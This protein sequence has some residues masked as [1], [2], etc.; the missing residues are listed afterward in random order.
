MKSRKKLWNI[1]PVRLHG[2]K[3]LVELQDFA[4]RQTVMETL[5]Q[6]DFKLISEQRPLSEQR[7]TPF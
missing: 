2:A 3:L 6:F 1:Q 4:R 5:T 7:R